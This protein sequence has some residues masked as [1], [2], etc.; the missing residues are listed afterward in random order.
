[1]SGGCERP[2]PDHGDTMPEW[3]RL[4]VAAKLLKMRAPDLLKRVEDNGIQ[5]TLIGD[6]VLILRSEVDKLQAQQREGKDEADG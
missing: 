1:M 4:G 2:C 6:T 3:V 5:H